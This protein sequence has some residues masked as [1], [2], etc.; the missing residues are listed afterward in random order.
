MKQRIMICAAAVLILA[1][2][3]A[4]A[5]MVD[6]STGGVVMTKVGNDIGYGEYDIVTL[7]AASG[8]L[9]LALY[10]PQEVVINTLTFD[11]GGSSYDS[12]YMEYTLT[13]DM[14][15]NGITK[16]LSQPMAIQID[17]SDTLYLYDGDPVM[18]GNVKVT[19]LGWATGFVN[20]GGPMNR[21]VSAEFVAV[22][23]PAAVLLGMLGLGAA[24]LKLRKSV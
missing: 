21:D 16:S 8:S 7:T 3:S 23:V 14:T 13:R 10:T 15:V 18:F 1:A 5:D 17:W 20:G 11:V 12:P 4:Q 9:P 2:V 19:P 22:P 24:G 6:W